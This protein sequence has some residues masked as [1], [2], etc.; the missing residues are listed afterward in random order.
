MAAG[1][2]HATLPRKL[3]EWSTGETVGWRI[4]AQCRIVRQARGM[5]RESASVSLAKGVLYYNTHLAV[6]G[7]RKIRT[8][9]NVYYKSAGVPTERFSLFTE[10]WRRSDAGLYPRLVGVFRGHDLV[11][12]VWENPAIIQ[13][14]FALTVL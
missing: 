10:L 9:G 12:D 6:S 13:R 8:G 4:S 7:E 5:Q 14:N 1:F 2:Q 3:N 11:D